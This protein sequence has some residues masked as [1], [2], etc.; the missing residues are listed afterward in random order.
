MKIEMNLSEIKSREFM[1]WF[2]E[3]LYNTD[4]MFIAEANTII[5]TGSDCGDH[6]YTIIPQDAI[7][8][9]ITDRNEECDSDYPYAVFFN[10][11]EVDYGSVGVYSEFVDVI[12]K[13]FFEKVFKEEE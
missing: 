9:T 8:I 10:I 1:S 13:E 6:I 12:S 3:I 7:N 4:Y 11:N 5:N 2:S